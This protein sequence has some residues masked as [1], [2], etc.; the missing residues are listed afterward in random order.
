MNETEFTNLSALFNEP[1]AAK[2]LGGVSTKHLFNLRKRGELPF[3]RI[4]RRVM[5]AKNSL[6]KMIAAREESGK[7]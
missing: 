4:G 3:V 6:E 7:A 2:F 5:Y 1:Q